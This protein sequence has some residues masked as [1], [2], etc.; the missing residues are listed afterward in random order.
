[1]TVKL[2]YRT[3]E[4]LREIVLWNNLSYLLTPIKFVKCDTHKEIFYQSSNR[5]KLFQFYVRTF[6]IRQNL[7]IWHLHVVR[8]HIFPSA[9]FTTEALR[10]IL[11]SSTS[12][13][14]FFP[15]RSWLQFPNEQF[16]SALMLSPEDISNVEPLSSLSS[17]LSNQSEHFATKSLHTSSPGL[18][19]I[20]EF[21]NITFSAW[22]SRARLQN[23]D[24]TRS[25]MIVDCFVC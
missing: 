5:I 3:F 6:R 11:T 7:I 13:R 14:T 19:W 2:P 16:S 10:G 20:S 18:R 12:F 15:S 8:Y 17:Q 21:R 9:Y 22:N 25:P 1:M 23:F 4:P 24:R